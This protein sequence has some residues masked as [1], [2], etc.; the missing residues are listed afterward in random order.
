MSSRFAGLLRRFGILPPG[1]SGSLPDDYV[2]PPPPGRSIG[3]AVT[4]RSAFGHSPPAAASLETYRQMRACPTVAIAR[5]AASA[6]IKAAPW[7]VDHAD[8]ADEELVGAVQEIIDLHRTALLR[9]AVTALDYGFAAWRIDWDIVDGLVVPVRIVPQ[10]PEETKALVDK[11]KPD[12][13]AAAE[14][15][16]VKVPRAK[17]LWHSSDSDG[18]G[19]YG[20]ARGENI[21]T[22]WPAWNDTLSRIGRYTAKSAGVVPMVEYPEGKSRDRTGS[23]ID[24]FEIA[25][26]VLSALGAGKGVAMPN[27]LV[28][29]ADEA[30]RRGVD[31][32]KL[33]AWSIQFLES[34]T[35]HGNEYVGIMR[36]MDSLIM[37]GWLVPERAATEGQMG[38]K[39]EAEAH[40]DVAVSAAEQEAADIVASVNRHVVQPM[41]RMNAGKAAENSVIIVAAPIDRETRAA[42]RQ[43]VGQLLTGPIGPDLALELVNL[44]AAFDAAGLPRRDGTDQEE[45]AERR[46]E[47][48][49]APTME[50]E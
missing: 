11:R 4:V 42:L 49:E 3:D 39:A 10:L 15:D 35:G 30:I 21:R 40:G 2:P 12:E 5:T 50:S 31:I 45:L 28:A 7:V 33:K 37:R 1:A 23:E 48:R 22:V 25:E 27:S 9:H 32:A 36:Y 34:G 16:G 38:T 29:W 44:D 17:V 18:V 6:P 20:R 19:F 46:R 14:F 43:I 13:L 24:N 47:L 41:L 26:K 8:D